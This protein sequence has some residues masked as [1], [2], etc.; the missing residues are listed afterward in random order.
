VPRYVSLIPYFKKNGYLLLVALL[1]FG[2]SYIVDYFRSGSANVNVIENNFTDYLQKAQKDFEAVNKNNELINFIYDDKLSIKRIEALE[3]KKY[4][5]F[6]Y[7]VNIVDSSRLVLWNT[8][9]IL[10]TKAIL[11][12]AETVGFTQLSNGYYVWFKQF[13]SRGFAIGLLPVK[14]NYIVTNEYLKN[15][16]VLEEGLSNHYRLTTTGNIKDISGKSLFGLE[17]IS[18]IPVS[19]NNAFSILL[20]LLG[21]FV[22]FI[23]IYFLAMYLLHAG[24][25][26]TKVFVYFFLV[27]F[28]LRLLSYY[29]PIPLNLRQFELFNP[30]IYGSGPVLKSLGDLLINVFL[31]LGYVLF[32]R[33]QMQKLNFKFQI[34]NKTI[35]WIVLL[36]YVF[37]LLA[38]TYVSSLVIRSLI[39][40]SSISFDVINFFSL[41][42]NSLIGFIILGCIGIIYF[43]L[44]QIIW[45]NIKA[46][47]KFSLAFL[48]III[49]SVGL[50][51]LTTGLVPMNSGFEIW[52]LVWLLIFVFVFDYNKVNLIASRFVVSKLIFWIFFFSVSIALM[53]L[54]ENN[55]KELR[56]RKHFAEILAH[57][58]DPTNETLLNSM[59][60]D[61]NPNFLFNHFKELSDP[62]ESLPFRDSL[63]NNNFSGYTNKYDTKVLVFDEKENPLFNRDPVDYNRLNTIYNTQARPTGIS[64]LYYYDQAYDKFSYISKRTIFN[65]ADSV[66][67]YVFV[68]VTPKSSEGQ[69]L[70]PELFSRG[71]NNALEKASNYAFAVYNN[72]FLI[73]RH[74]DYG[75]TTKIDS[76]SLGQNIFL[77]REINNY[78]ELWYNAGNGKIVVIVKENKF[79]IEAITLFSYLFCAFLLLAALFWFINILLRSRFNL[80]RLNVFLQ[81]TIRNQIHG[82][83]IFFSILSFVVIGIATILFFINKYES[84]NREKLSATI[85]IMEKEIS[86][87]MKEGW[88]LSDSLTIVN[89]I[90]SNSAENMLQK[91]SEIH[92]VDI[93][94]YNKDGNL[95]LSSLALPY[96]KGIVSTKMDP[97]AYYHL[98][99]EKSVQFFQKE[100]I[101]ELNFLSNYSPVL[102]SAGNNYAYLNIPYFTSQSKLKQE[103]SNFLITIINLNAFIFLIAGMVAF[104][105]TNRITNSFSVIAEKM[106]NL[107]IGQYNQTIAWKRNDEIGKLV[108][109][110]NKMVIK[111]E[112]SAQA[113]AKSEREGAWQEMARQVAHE[114]KNPLTPMKL[115]MQFLQRAIQN[116]AENIE[117]LT[118]DMTKTLIEQIDHLSNIASEFSQFAN[119]ESDHKQRINLTNEL[120]Q[121]KNLYSGHGDTQF[122]WSIPDEPA[123][124][125]G[126]TTQINR[127]FTNLIQN[128]LQAVPE[129]ETAYIKVNAL[130]NNKHIVISVEDN[131]EG[132]PE[133]LHEKIF[134]PNFTTKTSGTGLGLAMCKRIVEKSNGKI[135]FETSLESGTIF[136]VELP[137]MA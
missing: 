125:L 51:T 12:S 18:G 78:N 21:T 80:K 111:L 5:T 131:G 113:L 95:K 7:H 83:V 130:C 59:L 88:L 37:A 3:Q 117:Q 120:Q 6:F 15:D 86:L 137:L 17:E 109:E 71:Q 99:R 42:V 50:L 62:K 116:K 60:I 68:L 49:C 4:F 28:F 13:N 72:D 10:P 1:L 84:N 14:W 77:S 9:T 101:G 45:F 29:L 43:V 20:K 92:G 38:A 40:D 118:N 53:I 104:F 2:A 16:F 27:L 126:D 98:S 123:Y 90:E 69:T 55:K 70:Y 44:I 23:F 31:A 133:A 36:L 52:L 22:I 124:V 82:T 127:L 57:K 114:I 63:I 87:A 75:F 11:T 136:F 96:L 119:I 110:Y 102:D 122:S 48:Y 24:Y 26:P 19:Q 34:N 39:A 108:S 66:M 115:G 81:L 134:T 32:V 58:S 33:I 61:F 35:R 89:T 64:Y 97:A 94:I 103:I 128:A 100:K 132:I 93:N 105:I 76:G 8:Q 25:S 129:E 67:G 74:N 135:Y 106:K 65:L 30:V 79:F 47:F 54:T 56:E 112:E 121:I 85:Q 41:S 46:N 73:N 107:N 91:I